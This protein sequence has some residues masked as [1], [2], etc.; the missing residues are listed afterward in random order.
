MM[1]SQD[2]ERAKLLTGPPPIT[3]EVQRLALRTY[4]STSAR[5]LA[6]PTAERHSG[7]N[8][9]ADLTNQSAS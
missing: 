2:W 5:K 8:S 3:Y 1:S 6:A 7:L 4:G 9:T